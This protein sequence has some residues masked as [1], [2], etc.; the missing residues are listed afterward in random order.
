MTLRGRGDMYLGSFGGSIRCG[1]GRINIVAA[2][3]LR[4]QQH[5]NYPYSLMSCRRMGCPEEASVVSGIGSPR[6]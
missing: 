6:G 3:L 4:L 2:A 1:P 5:P